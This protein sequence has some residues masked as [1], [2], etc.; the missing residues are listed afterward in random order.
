MT[1]Q[2]LGLGSELLRALERLNYAEPTKIQAAS[3]PVVNEGKDIFALAQTGTGKTA[4]FLLPI[5]QGSL[6]KSP[7]VLILLPTRE[8]AQQVQQACLGYSSYLEQL[9]V[10]LITGGVP[11]FKHKKK[12]NAPL[13]IMIGTPGRVL[14]YTRTGKVDFKN[15]EFLVL[16]EADRMLDMGFKDE[17]TEIVEALPAEKQTLL[18]SATMNSKDVVARGID[19]PSVSHVI[20]Y[21]IP[22]EPDDYIHRIGRTGRASSEGKAITLAYQ[23]E[24]G[25]LLRIEKHMGFKINQINLEGFDE[26]EL[27]DRPSSGGRNRGR[28]R[29][30]Y[31][32]RGRSSSRNGN[33]RGSSSGRGRSSNNRGGSSEGRGNSSDNRGR[34][35][36]GR[37]KFSNNR[38]GSSDNRGGSS[39]GRGRSSNNRGGSSAGKSKFSGNRSGSTKGGSSNNRGSSNGRSGARKSSRPSRGRNARS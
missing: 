23:K 27:T 29:G 38:N 19:V 14:D 18:F 5:L 37:G 32:S 3:I 16:D 8:L 30:G 10:S 4:A 11:Y 21:D 25:M 6:F 35:S 31:S 39:E 28:S 7:R 34:S 13:D 2:D 15:V 26:L 12:L 36:E 9:K 33:G 17:V 22:R 24:Y 1:F 20:N